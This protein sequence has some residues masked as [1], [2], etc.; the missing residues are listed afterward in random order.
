[1]NPYIDLV[2]R[3]ESSDA[4]RKLLSKTLPRGLT[5]QDH[6][7]HKWEYDKM[8]VSSKKLRHVPSTQ[9]F[10]VDYLARFFLAVFTGAML[11]APIIAMSFVDSQDM[12]LIISSIP[13]RP[14]MRGVDG[15]YTVSSHLLSGYRK[16]SDL[17]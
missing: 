7:Q 2:P 6:T 11:M 5:A 4:I 16:C 14:P 1:M 13:M 15:M 12:R 8:G 3:N 17:R 9:T 10:A